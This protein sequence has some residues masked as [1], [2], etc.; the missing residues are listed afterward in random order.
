M[1]FRCLHHG[2]L[3]GSR[4]CAANLATSP[5]PA[6][7]KV[8]SAGAYAGAVAERLGDLSSGGSR[9][10]ADQCH[11]SDQRGLEF[12]TGVEGWTGLDLRGHLA[13]WWNREEE[14]GPTRR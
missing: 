6:A 11:G 7:L 8:Q 1:A 4:G 12:G 9:A 2:F 3:R 14:W 13:H 10:A 5:Y